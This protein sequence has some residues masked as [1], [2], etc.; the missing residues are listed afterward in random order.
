MARKKN[1]SELDFE[2]AVSDDSGAEESSFDDGGSEDVDS[3]EDVEEGEASEEEPEPNRDGKRKRETG[4]QKQTAKRAKQKV[5]KTNGEEV[6]EKGVVVKTQSR[7]TKKAPNL[8]GVKAFATAMKNFD[9]SRK[10]LVIE[11]GFGGLLSI[12]LAFIPRKFV[13]WLLTRVMGYGL[14]TFVDEY[15]LPLSPLQVEYVLPCT[16]PEDKQAEHSR[17]LEKFGKNDSIS[18]VATLGAL[19][20]KD[21]ESNVFLL[22]DDEKADFKI[23]F[24][25]AALGYALSA[26]TNTSYLG[27]KLVPS[28]LVC[29]EAF[30]YDWCTYVFNWMVVAA[31]SFQKKFAHDGYVAGSGGCILYLL[32][33]KIGYLPPYTKCVMK[34]M[35]QLMSQC[36]DVANAQRVIGGKPMERGK[37]MEKEVVVHE[38]L[39]GENHDDVN[40]ADPNLASFLLEKEQLKQGR[41][42]LGEDPSTDT[43]SSEDDLECVVQKIKVDPL[44][45]EDG[46]EFKV[47]GDESKVDGVDAEVDEGVVSDLHNCSDTEV[48]DENIEPGPQIVLGL[49]TARG[50][51]VLVDAE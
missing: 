48:E 7:N 35:H 14:I 13:Y 18:L 21:E 4:A 17:I 31:R 32:V 39:S 27:V 1:G 24:L 15:V 50:T 5:D 37:P 26:T 20:R 46:G 34:S 41:E 9:D 30:E 49:V 44:F 40:G 38:N 2:D 33:S 10:K 47:V 25:I 36:V 29:D 43:M 16:I 51:T 11:M 45:T 19:I 12:H 3:E 8:H 6:K 23:A 22:S 42:G 28:L